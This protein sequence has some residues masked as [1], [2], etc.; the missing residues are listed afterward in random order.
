MCAWKKTV[1]GLIGAVFS[2]ASFA[3]AWIPPEAPIA[4]EP[5]SFWR[6][7]V[8]LSGGGLWTTHAGKSQ[9]FPIIDSSRYSYAIDNGNQSKGIFGAFGGVEFALNPMWALQLGVSYYQAGKFHPSGILTQGVDPQSSDQFA[10]GY[11]IQSRQVLAES[12]LLMNYR[13]RFHPYISLGLGGAFN[14]ASNYHVTYPR[15][16]TFTPKFEDA[17]K[18]SFSYNLGAGL[19]FDVTS[20]IRVGVGYRFADLGKVSLGQG[21]IDTTP[22]N[23]TLNQSNFYTNQV[24]AQLSFLY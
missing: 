20:H 15:F 4:V 9:V 5:V 2:S 19:D 6:P 24:L 14:K 21:R 23:S 16:L 12:K 17:S 10:Y 11:N 8:T 7:L 3:G 18:T 1:F 13:E 22:I